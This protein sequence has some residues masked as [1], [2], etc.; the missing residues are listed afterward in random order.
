MASRS[1]SFAPNGYEYDDPAKNPPNLDRFYGPLRNYVKMVTGGYHRLFMLDAYGGLGKTYNVKEVLQE[2]LE[3]D[4]WTHQRGF[5]TPVELYKTLY[6]AQHGDQV[7]FLDDMSGIRN[8]QKALD[9]LKAATE[10]DGPENWIEYRTSQDIAHPEDS[11]QA[12]PNTFCFRGSIIMS[13]NDTPDSPDFQALKDRSVFYHFSL[14]YDER[15][16]LVRE[17]AKLPDFS[18][19]TVSEQQEVAEWIATATNPAIEVSLRTFEEVCNMRHYGQM[20][21]HNWERMALEVFDLDYE[22]HL[23]IRMREND[24]MKV[25][26]QIEHFKEETGMSESYYYKLLNDIKSERMD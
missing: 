19:L 17:A 24:D 1:E 16:D 8:K 5:T 23:I 4:Q 6:Q 9:M 7:L 14:D 21:G 20:E 13:F 25:A 12:L 11:T 15:L 26:H 2:E 10:S 3:P 22:R 18:D